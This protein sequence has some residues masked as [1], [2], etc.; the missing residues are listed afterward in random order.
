MLR[1][2]GKRK[3]KKRKKKN[4]HCFILYVFEDILDNNN[5]NR[6]LRCMLGIFSV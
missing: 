5:E 6:L 3:K 4:E 1:G 2:N